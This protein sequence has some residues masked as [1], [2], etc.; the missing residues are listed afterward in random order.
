MAKFPYP[1]AVPTDEVQLLISTLTGGTK[2][3]TADIAH[4]VWVIQGYLQSLILSG[5]PKARAKF[6]IA[7]ADS[8][9]AVKLTDAE[10]VAALGQLINDRKAKGIVKAQGFIGD[11]VGN[12]AKK[13]L[14][15]LLLPLLQK[16]LISFLTE[17]GLQKLIGRI[18]KQ[19][20][21]IEAKPK[22]GDGFFGR[23]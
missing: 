8:A 15:T 16:W 12:F 17:G 22:R 21:K 20:P 2:A 6:R 3:V 4:D 5:T 10:A 11:L 9:P 23:R 7:S 19:A 14:A 18:G 13:Q 1:K